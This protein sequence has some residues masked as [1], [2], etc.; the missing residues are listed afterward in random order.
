VNVGCE[1]LRPIE[2]QHLA[3][4]FKRVPPTEHELA[5]VLVVSVNP[6]GQKAG[7]VDSEAT[8]VHTLEEG[9]F[10]YESAM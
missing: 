1:T 10:T 9:K 5:N 6:G 7:T 4:A 3:L 2:P 8:P